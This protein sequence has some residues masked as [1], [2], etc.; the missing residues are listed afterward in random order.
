[1][2]S[3]AFSGFFLIFLHPNGVLVWI[4][5][6]HSSTSFSKSVL[7]NQ[8]FHTS[9]RKVPKLQCFLFIT[10]FFLRTL[11]QYIVPF[12]L[13]SLT[14]K[15]SR[16]VSYKLLLFEYSLSCFSYF[17]EFRID[18]HKNEPTRRINVLFS[19]FRLQYLFNNKHFR[20]LRAFTVSD[21]PAL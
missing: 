8:S 2:C 5:C 12:R 10:Y 16:Q 18:L 3:T 7:L 20:P 1:M 21:L 14:Q 15:S 17:N 9:T 19:A 4:S 13:A 11:S 6:R